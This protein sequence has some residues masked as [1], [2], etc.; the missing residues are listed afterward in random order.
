MHHP[1][2]RTVHTTAL[3]TPYV[4]HWLE[5]EIVQWVDSLMHSIYSFNTCTGVRNTSMKEI[6]TLTGTNL[7][8]IACSVV[9]HE[10]NKQ[11]NKINK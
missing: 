9:Y 5:R 8:P 2:D 4:E 6:I 7:R 1:T 11:T 10:I 3:F